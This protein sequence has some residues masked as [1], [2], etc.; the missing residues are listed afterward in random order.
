MDTEKHDFLNLENGS[1]IEYYLQPY[2]LEGEIVGGVLSF[3]DVTQEKQTEAIIKHQALHDALTHLPNRIF[4][5]QKLAAALDSVI[6]D[7]KLIA[8]M[9]LDL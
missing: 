5:N 8:V 4:F 9:F 1:I 7:S 6:T 2:H 3:R